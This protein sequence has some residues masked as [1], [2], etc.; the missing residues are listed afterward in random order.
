M[1]PNQTFLIILW[2]CL[3]IPTAFDNH[4]SFEL[5]GYSIRLNYLA[6]ALSL[7]LYS[8]PLFFSF[9]TQSLQNH[10]ARLLSTLTSQR[11]HIFFIL[12]FLSGLI[13]LFFSPVKDNGAKE[14]SFI[15]WLW[16]FFTVM[17]IPY[18]LLNTEKTLKEWFY[19]LFFIYYTGCVFILLWDTAFLYLNRHLLIGLSGNAGNIPRPHLFK[20]E[21]GYLAAYWSICL[22]C[23]RYMKA[24][25][26]L[27]GEN[28]NKLLSFFH[29]H[30]FK[31]YL[32][33][34]LCLILCFSKMGLVVAFYLIVLEVSYQ[35][36]IKSRRPFIKITY[37]TVSI[38]FI[39][40]IFY[41]LFIHQTYADD[42]TN[43]ITKYPH[44]VKH[45]LVKNTIANATFA[46]N[47]DLFDK[48]TIR[49]FSTPRI[50]RGE[51]GFKVFLNE[52]LLGVG[53]GLATHYYYQA[54]PVPPNPN[55]SPK[56]QPL[57]HNLY[58]ELLSEWGLIG[59]FLFFISLYFIF[60]SHSL[61]LKLQ[62][63]G[64]LFLIYATAETLARFDLWFFIFILWL[65]T[66]SLSAK[67]DTQKST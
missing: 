52:P 32:L 25:L 9:K 13:S 67:K 49:P 57:S 46:F 30:S 39:C 8:L 53:P 59:T 29:S 31:L 37:L 45:H 42:Q 27:N 47:A 3:L 41:Y 28:L 26:S 21:P 7:F 10:Y 54:Y 63:Y 1:K 19:I 17:A 35:F 5:A 12:F 60:S 51:A 43:S 56:R 36:F 2:S 66:S 4:F 40:S 48:D 6:L 16:G 61:L 44:Y 20:E 55:F 62:I 38:L 23:M 65:I 18:V 64:S 22:L 24:R 50:R 58:T 14:H 15:Y 34:I 33:G 11:F